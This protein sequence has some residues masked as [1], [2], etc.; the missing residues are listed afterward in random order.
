MREYFLLRY[1]MRKDMLALGVDM[2]RQFHILKVYSPVCVC[3]LCKLSCLYAWT[4]TAAVWYSYVSV[5]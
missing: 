1:A 4:Y 2:F 3:V 5:T